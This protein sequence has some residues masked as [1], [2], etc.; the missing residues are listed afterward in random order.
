MVGSTLAFETT[1][2]LLALPSCSRSL[3]LQELLRRKETSCRRLNK[4]LKQAER[5][6]GLP[7]IAC[8]TIG[9]IGASMLGARATGGIADSGGGSVSGGGGDWLAVSSDRTVSGVMTVVGN[10]VPKRFGTC[11]MAL[12]AGAPAGRIHDRFST[13][14][15]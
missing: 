6:R 11:V 8:G 13:R 2:P 5:F 9:R 15:T 4:P 12:G 1:L 7:T 14:W 10:E 3:N